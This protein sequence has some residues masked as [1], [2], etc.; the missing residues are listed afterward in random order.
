ML[1]KLYFGLC[2][3][4]LFNKTFTIPIL[5]YKNYDFGFCF[6]FRLKPKQEVNPN[7]AWAL[8]CILGSKNNYIMLKETKI[9]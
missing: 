2:N 5:S 8:Y 1:F 4:F 9:V 6:Y 3:S 7:E